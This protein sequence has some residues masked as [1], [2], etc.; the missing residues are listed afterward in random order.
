MLASLLI[1]ITGVG[2]QWQR[3]ESHRVRA[4]DGELT[5][6]RNLYAAHMA[7]AQRA[8]AQCDLGRALE[9][10][11]RH[12]RQPGPANIPAPSAEVDLRGWEWR[13][14][15]AC[16]QSDEQ[17]AIDQGSNSVTAVAYSANGHWLAVRRRPG[18]MT[19]WDLRDAADRRKVMEQRGGQGPKALAFAPH[20]DLLAWGSADE[21][22]R[23]GLSLWH[24]APPQPVAWLPHSAT[25]VSVAFS[26][27][28]SALA[29]LAEDG[30]IRV[31]ETASRRVLQDLRGDKAGTGS[32]HDGC[33]R[34]S[35]DGQMLVAGGEPP[36]I[37]RWHWVTG[38][39][40]RSILLPKPENSVVSLAFSPDG[41]F[42]A[43]ATGD[44]DKQVHLFDV[45]TGAERQF[46][47]HLSWISDLAFSSDGQTLATAS[48]DQTIRLWDVRQGTELR[49]FQGHQNEVYCL[50]W[51]PD[52]PDGEQIASGGKDSSVRV[53]NPAAPS[54]V[55]S[56]TTLPS[57][58]LP[59]GLTFSPDSRRFLTAS[60]Y[61]GLTV[62]WDA[63]SL[64][65]VERLDWLGSGTVSFAYLA[66]RGLLVV[67]YEQ[68]NIRA[69]DTTSR[70]AVANLTFSGASVRELALS[71]SGRTLV[72]LGQQ[73]GSGW[74]LK[75]WETTRW[76]EI[77]LPGIELTNLVAASLAPDER[78]LA[79]SFLGGAVKWWNLTTQRQT[80]SFDWQHLGSELAVAF[81]PDGRLFA[82]G[83]D[84]GAMILVDVVSRAQRIIAR[85]HLTRITA[86]VF[87]PDGLRLATAGTEAADL[88]K[89]WDPATGQ[90]LATLDG[91]SGFYEHLDFSPDGNIL[92]AAGNSGVTLLWH[93]PSR[94]Q[95]EQGRPPDRRIGRPLAELPPAAAA[96]RL[97]S[98]DGVVYRESFDTHPHWAERGNVQG[99]G[100]FVTNGQAVLRSVLDRP[101]D[102]ARPDDSHSSYIPLGGGGNTRSWQV[103]FQPNR[104]VE[105][106]MD[107]IGANQDDAFAGFIV[108]FRIN[109]Y[110]VLLDRNEIILAK[111]GAKP[112][113]FASC[114]FWEEAILPE[115]NLTLSAA[116]TPVGQD[117]KIRVQVL[118][119][120]RQSVLYEREAVDTAGLDPV[121][122]DGAVKR[123]LMQAER[124]PAPYVGI[125]QPCV[126]LYYLNPDH[127]PT[128]PVEV[129]IDNVEVRDHMQRKAATF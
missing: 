14:L 126:G 40:A 59:L 39:P 107:W 101:T 37:Q 32:S 30:R 26:P 35:P 23:P 129:T 68:G 75:L 115:T 65:E 34:F 80:A 109:G 22:G 108:D 67:G 62:A 96:P 20:G 53:W 28:A 10:L 92:F 15:W 58:T 45:E 29:A 5:A 63:Q 128:G 99:G 84:Q 3:A 47:G 16:C 11:N 113:W 48:A 60:Y 46:H 87:T 64:E 54:V 124:N 50:A 120:T 105:L 52:A 70:F 121:L 7:L 51:S 55:R 49:R 56:C 86:L 19:L 100:M 73:G 8:L 36:R 119:R 89:I 9:L 18:T 33:V 111:Y 66:D 93:A 77:Q 102:P 94:E 24:A 104:T 123:M 81:S 38:V 103:A 112:D 85:A 125:Q 91:I 69:W 21:T 57:G 98:T 71:K 78:T 88:I 106:R 25:V 95:I 61:G 127:P 110:L 90:E 1:G 117:L 72:A 17:C 122:P 42:L 41:R 44:P 97:D 83:G 13:Y 116:F 82:A 79:L 76:Q 2:W 114:F 4:E 43:V 12:R 6:R 118:D 27:D 74:S 31:W